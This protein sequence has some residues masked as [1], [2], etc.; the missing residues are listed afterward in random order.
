MVSLGLG[1]IKTVFRASKDQLA[2]I[3]IMASSS[4]I[5]DHVHGKIGLKDTYRPILRG[6]VEICDL[7]DRR[8]QI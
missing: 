3:V 1:V 7:Y 8:I 5:E 2:D 6:S 4:I